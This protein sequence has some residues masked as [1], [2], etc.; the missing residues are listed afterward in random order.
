MITADALA[1][2]LPRIATT[3]APA[4]RVPGVLASHYAPR[5]LCFR[6]PIKL[7]ETPLPR[8]RVGLLSPRHVNWPVARFW[9]MPARPEDYARVLYS[10]LHEADTSDCDVLLIALPPDDL[11]WMAVHDRVRRATR[12]LALTH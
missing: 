3:A 4:P 5:K 6:I 9:L 2:Y 7:S 1:Q 12:S 11:Q 8:Q 10:T